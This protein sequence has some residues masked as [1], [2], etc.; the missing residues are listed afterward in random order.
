MNQKCLRY[1]DANFAGDHQT[2]RSTS[3]M[4]SKYNGGVITWSS[5]K[6]RS[7]A[8]STTE[9]EFV[10]VCEGAKEAIWLSRLLNEISGFSKIPVL[11]IDN[12]QV[13]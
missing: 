1:T 2:K 8:L 9:A 12:A 11:F 3:G 5:Q 13:Q 4:L 10:A 6:Q 7:I